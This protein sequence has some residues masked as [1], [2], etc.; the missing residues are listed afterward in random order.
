MKTFIYM[1]LLSLTISACK[2][3]EV[4]NMDDPSLSN[5]DPGNTTTANDTAMSDTST[6]MVDS[7]R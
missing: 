3:N 5:P 7:I 6:I 1:V 4:R 2:N